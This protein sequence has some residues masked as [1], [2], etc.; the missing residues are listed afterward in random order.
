M[1]GFNYR[2]TEI[3]AAIGRIQ[4]RK[5]EGFNR[6]R[7]D[8]VHYIESKLSHIP[9]LSFPKVR[10]DAE[11]VYYVHACK[12]DEQ[13]AGIG[14]NTF[15]DAVRAELPYHKLREQEGVK[16]S[17]GYVKPL[18]L[19]PMFQKRTAYGSSGYPFSQSDIDYNEGICPVVERM[20]SS[21]LFLHEFILPS[22]KK[23]D[24]DDVVLAFD[25]VWKNRHVLQ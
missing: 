11:H 2:M 21:E 6:K 9:A 3:E 7:I 17:S 5:L 8:N 16:I 18:Y 1:I 4:L 22:M 14:R 23:N 20:F 25:K 13:I 19:Q 15:I 12:F 24:I 10:K